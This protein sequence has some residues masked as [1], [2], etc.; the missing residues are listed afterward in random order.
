[1][2]KC[3]FVRVCVRVCS[4]VQCYEG[5]VV[6]E[7]IPSPSPLLGSTSYA[8][9]DTRMAAQRTEVCIARLGFRKRKARRC[10]G[11]VC[12]AGEITVASCRRSSQ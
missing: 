11:S 3:V 2:I 5:A 6:Q 9:L 10:A 7:R 12:G 1:M 8:W 4:V